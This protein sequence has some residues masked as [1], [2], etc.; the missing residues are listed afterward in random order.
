MSGNQT[1]REPGYGAVA[2]LLHWLIVALLVAQFLIGWTMPDIRRGTKPEG[3]ISLHLSV[4]LL[5]LFIVVIRILWRLSHPVPLLDDGQPY[6]QHRAAEATH[7]L[8]YLILFF[9]PLMGW[10]NA[11][12][13]GWTMHFFGLFTLPALVS[14]GSAFGHELGDIHILT[15]YVLL[16]LIG[17]HVLATLYHQFWLRD[18]VLARMLPGRD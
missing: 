7:G 18:R 1:A 4:G 10:A 14:S 15:S 2:K 5:I 13:R 12:S 17:L 8:L 6:W 11:S 9:L 3:L 16:A